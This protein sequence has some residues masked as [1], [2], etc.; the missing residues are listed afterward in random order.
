MFLLAPS[1]SP[2]GMDVKDA[3]KADVGVYSRTVRLPTTS[4]EQ[5]A[6]A[7]K[8]RMLQEWWSTNHVYEN[9]IKRSTGEHFTLHDGPPYA[10]GDLHIGHALNKIL[11]D[12]INKYQTLQGRKVRY[13]PGW[14]CHGLPIELKV[15]H[16]LQ[17]EERATLSPIQLRKKALQFATDA[18]E[19]QKAAFKRYG[20]WGDWSTPYYTAQP[21]YEAAQINV[22]GK[23][24]QRGYI[25][26]GKKPVHWSPSSRTAL[27][28]AELEYPENH[29]S[30][31]V[32]A[33]F[34]ALSLAEKLR[35]IVPNGADV[36]IPV[37]TTTPWTIPANAAV[38]VNGEVEYCVVTHPQVFNGAHF[39]VGRPLVDALGAKLGLDAGAG[40]ALQVVGVLRGDELVG[41]TYQHPL[42]DRVASVV[43]G[44]DYIQMESGTGL[45]HTAPGHGQEDYQT[46]LKYGLPLLSP[47]N[48][49]GQFTD[50]AGERFAGKDV[51]KEGNQEVITALQ[52]AG[53]LIK[54]EPYQHKYPYD[55]R[56]KKPT[57]VR[58]TEQWFA[59]VDRFRDEALRAIDTVEWIPAIGRNRITAM[60]QSR[61]DWCISRQRTWGVPI[62]VFYHVSDNEPLMTPETL[63][64]IEKVFAQHGS[65]AWWEM[66]VAEL[67]PEGELRQVAGQYTK[68]TDTMDV[69]FD[70]GTSWAGVLQASQQLSPTTAEVPTA[71]AL[72]YPADL[73]LEGSD[74]HRGWFQSSL[75]TSVAAQGR[76]PYKTV[77]THGFVLDEKGRKMSKSLGNVMDP[78][79]IISGGP[80]LKEQPAYGADTLRWWVSSVDYTGD[81]SVGAN[82][83]KQVAESCRKLR[84][85]MRFL[86]GNLNDYNPAEHAVPYAQLP[87][88]D[89]Y[90]LGKLSALV[91]DID[92]AYGEYQFSRV[93]QA[94]LQ[95]VTTDLSAFYLD[96]AKD[97]LYISAQD[98]PRRRW[99]QTV[100]AALLEQLCVAIAPIVPH[101]AEE[102][103]QHLPYQAPTLSVFERGW[104]RPDEL[105]PVF[106]EDRWTKV[107]AL[108][109]DVNKCIDLARTAK[110]VRAS[111]ETKVY[112]HATNKTDEALLRGMLLGDVFG[113]A[114]G[115]DSFEVSTT[116]PA[117]AVDDLRFILMASQAEI[118]SSW[119]E[120]QRLCPTYRVAATGTGAGSGIAVGV[121]RVEGTKCERCWFYSPHVGQDPVHSTICLRCADAIVGTS[122]GLGVNF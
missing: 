108:R 45:V 46:G 117:A 107:R 80:N 64:H 84:N 82:I 93:N 113:R 68:G 74:Q 95:F 23:M 83:M 104:V 38:A 19:T 34:Q 86:L 81:V 8:E 121:V 22:F 33:A 32:Y 122:T 111:M 72:N 56:T 51:L 66:S 43:V 26:R 63:A 119:E 18:M 112:L 62:P 50:E 90:M 97:R 29:V 88:L 92:A 105:F 52:E 2:G 89:K 115:G 91:R 110:D 87:S 27:A 40:Q 57:I 79:V 67:L 30:R 75:L 49:L 28:E 15:L 12:I 48:D 4:F 42:C 71:G 16:S 118:V 5:R 94:L 54:E 96:I 13:V 47:V 41:T 70:S 7:V 114:A 44:G 25:Y 10:N 11:K 24:V 6:D 9:L 39:V 109:N 98:D 58:A 120:L 14:D 69:W 116:G 35:T 1:G 101:L 17:G 77:L 100:L 53:C 55:W 102:V 99:C 20:V 78:A 103:W 60:A 37:W 31:S 61:G 59:S 3:K 21:A 73:Y 36:R 76:A 85:T 106:E 65:D